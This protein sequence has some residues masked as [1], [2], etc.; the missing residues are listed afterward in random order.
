[1]SDNS[2]LRDR[3]QNANENENVNHEP[4]VLVARLVSDDSRLY[5]IERVRD[6]IYSL[7]RLGWWVNEG[8]VLVAGKSSASLMMSMSYGRRS[9]SVKTGEG[10]SWWQVARIDEPLAESGLLGKEDGFGVSVVF[11][12]AEGFGRGSDVDS[13]G[14]HLSPP[15][16]GGQPGG[17]FRHATTVDMA[18]ERSSSAN[19]LTPAT[20]MSREQSENENNV[21]ADGGSDSKSPQEMLDGLREQYLQALYISKVSYTLQWLLCMAYADPLRHHLHTLPKVHWH[22]VVRLFS[23]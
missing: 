13:S 8:E 15:D 16:S 22:V 6:G 12:G 7:S 2:A 9:P 20:A 1:M 18:V 10:G 11:G 21:D 4:V 19:V 5:V 23:R 14:H 3:L 17:G